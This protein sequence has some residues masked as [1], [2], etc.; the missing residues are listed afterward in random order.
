MKLFL[1]ICCAA[2]LVI[3]A[4]C[5]NKNTQPPVDAAMDSV[6]P[7]LSKE[8]IAEREAFDK[9][10]ANYKN[11]DYKQLS[12]LA[13]DIESELCMVEDEALL[14]VMADMKHEDAIY[15]LSRLTSRDSSYTHKF[16]PLTEYTDKISIAETDEETP[17]RLYTL[18][19]AGS[20]PAANCILQ[21][22]RNDTIISKYILGK[23]D[24]DLVPFYTKI[25]KTKNGYVV[26]TYDDSAS[27]TIS[28][29]FF[30]QEEIEDDDPAADDEDR[31]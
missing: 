3:N 23:E 12:S 18:Y 2:L 22:K 6:K 7:V 1:R 28:E 4:A 30:N 13:T 20:N 21:T 14:A 11:M 8:E 15:V 24:E 26:S 31:D 16:N 5:D 27:D 9:C 29:D 17:V 19:A 10:V 25:K